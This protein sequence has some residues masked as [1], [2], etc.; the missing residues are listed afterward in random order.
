MKRALHCNAPRSLRSL[1]R[2]ILHQFVNFIFLVDV[3]LQF[4]LHYQ[5]PKKQVRVRVRVTE[6]DHADSEPRPSANLHPTLAPSSKHVVRR[7]A[8]GSV[9]LTG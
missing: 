8:S 9:M 2:V 3:G 4:F 6:F 5:L 7:A 1:T